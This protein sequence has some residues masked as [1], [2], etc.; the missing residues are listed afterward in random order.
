MAF[1]FIKAQIFALFLISID[2]RLML[3]YDKIERKEKGD[4]LAINSPFQGGFFHFHEDFGG[5]K[6]ITTKYP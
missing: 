6:Y 3:Y 2:I 4:N 5:D 1:V